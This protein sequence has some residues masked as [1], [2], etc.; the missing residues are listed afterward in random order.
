MNRGLSISHIGLI[1]A[2]L[3]IGLAGLSF[4]FPYGAAIADM[5]LE[6]Y[7]VIALIAGAVWAALPFILRQG[8]TERP[9]ILTVFLIGLLMRGAMC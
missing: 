5:P 4:R 7:I 9:A 3:V 8:S 2:A 6:V 1:L